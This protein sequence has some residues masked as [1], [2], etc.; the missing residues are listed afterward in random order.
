MTRRPARRVPV[1]V[2]PV[3]ALL[4]AACGPDGART[5]VAADVTGT[6][7]TPCA[8]LVVLGARGS[9]QDPDLNS[10]VGTEVRRVT[11]H[12]IDRLAERT[13]LTL[14]L[15]AIRYDSSLAGSVAAYD[16]QT[17]DG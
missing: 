11:D 10:G 17:T 15:E 13:D 6:A 8:D 2:A 9:T 1:L 7:S 4:L 14:G 16:A 5:P 3:A 12:L